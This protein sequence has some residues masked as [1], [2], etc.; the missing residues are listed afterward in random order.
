MRHL[1]GLTKTQL[2]SF[3]TQRQSLSTS[4]FITSSCAPPSSFPP[5]SKPQLT[6]EMKW[7]SPAGSLVTQRKM[8]G[9]VVGASTEQSISTGQATPSLTR[10]T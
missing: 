2:R 3:T 10:S 1:V 9:C 8:G 5:S 6:T 4:S 7:I